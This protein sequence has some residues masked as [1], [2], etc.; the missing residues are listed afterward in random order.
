MNSTSNTAVLY[1]QQR[2]EQHW[3][4]LVQAEQQGASPQMLENLYDMY[5][6]AVEQY[7]RCAALVQSAQPGS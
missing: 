7:N 3:Y 2:M 1:A 5:I 4:A 6:R